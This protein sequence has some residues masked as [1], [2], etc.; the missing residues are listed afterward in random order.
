MR[1]AETEAVAFGVPIH[2][3]SV[4]NNEGLEALESYF[5]D[6]KTVAL[7]G[8]S[9]V[10]KSTLINRLY[11]EDIQKV[12]DIRK[13]DARGRHTT[14]HRELILLPGG[15]ILIDTPG[16]RELQLWE[17]EESLSHSFHDIEALA[18]LCKFRDCR[19][20]GEPGCAIQAALEEG[21]L[22]Q[23]RFDNY[24]KLQKE[25][26]YLERKTSKKSQ[27]EEREKW[28]KIAGDRTRVQRQR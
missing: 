8:S 22:D 13:D 6:N 28:K 24:L 25:L 20:H 2:A 18:A 11:G 17:K 26:A 15:G 14:T 7:L 10:G 21:T 27:Q 1:R 12:K 9:G 4:A 23:S 3:I 16:M 5:Q 19:H